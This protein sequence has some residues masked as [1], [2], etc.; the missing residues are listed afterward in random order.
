MGF[1]HRVYRV[2]D[3]RAKILKGMSRSLGGR[4]GNTKWFEISEIIEDTVIREKNIFPN[5][6]FYSASFYHELGIATDL[7]PAIFAMSRMSGW[8]AH[9]LEQKADNRLIRPRAEYIGPR[10]A[11]YV[12]LE[13]RS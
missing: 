1:G 11:A 2:M 4:H 8:T 5:V 3:P 9:V 12:P 6:D 10:D 13:D 7:F